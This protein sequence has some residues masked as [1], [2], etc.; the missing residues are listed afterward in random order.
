MEMSFICR[1]IKDLILSAASLKVECTEHTAQV[2]GVWGVKVE[3]E[4]PQWQPHHH[5]HNKV[6]LR[7]S[8]CI[9][10]VRVWGAEVSSKKAGYDHAS[11]VISIPSLSTYSVSM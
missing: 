4:R 9:S 8:L 6:S 10:D 11:E 2:I 1:Q 3:T 7:L 5:H